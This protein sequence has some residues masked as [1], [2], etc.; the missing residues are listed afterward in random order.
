MGRPGG[1]AL[2]QLVAQGQALL[3]AK[4]VLLINNGQC[5]VFEMHLVLND[6]VGA[7]HQLGFASGNQFQHGAT[8]F[9][10]LRASEP[11]GGDAQRL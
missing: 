9:G 8:L 1:D 7:H 5:Q 2:L 11:S 6:R 3:N 4:A 10:L